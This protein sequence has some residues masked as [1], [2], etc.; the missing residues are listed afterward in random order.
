MVEETRL[1]ANAGRL[2][3]PG[4]PGTD[5]ALKGAIRG[6]GEERVGVVRHEQEDVR[7][8]GPDSVSVKYGFQNRGRLLGCSQLVFAAWCRAERDEK[9]RP[10]FNPRRNVVVQASTVRE[11]WV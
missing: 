3:L 1:P 6:N 8:P 4:F 2:G 5:G 9:Y 7:P 11:R 10:V